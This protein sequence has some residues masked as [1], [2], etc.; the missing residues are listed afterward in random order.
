VLPVS[1]T[2]DVLHTVLAPEELDRRL[3]LLLDDSS[4]LM[5]EQ[6]VN[7]LYLAV[8]DLDNP[9]RYV[10]GITVDGDT[11]R[12][13]RSSRDR[14]RTTDGVLNG[15]GW[16]LHRIWSLEW[17]KRPTEQLNKLVEMIESA[18]KRQPR[19]KDARLAS[20]V[21]TI[22]RQAGGP[23]PLSA[24]TGAH[25]PL[26]P[27]ATRPEDPKSEG[28]SLFSDI[29]STGLKVGAAVFVAEKGKGLDAAID[30]LSKDQQDSKDQ[31]KPKK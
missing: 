23:D 28:G 26:P 15:Q 27:G 20:T 21:S 8:V 24:A 6:G 12:T 29:V 30:M 5:Q 2:A 14:N 11:F 19:R 31:K 13:A 22:P 1:T 9:N 3:V 7:V 10:L 25:Q 18:R 4:T 16:I 17:F